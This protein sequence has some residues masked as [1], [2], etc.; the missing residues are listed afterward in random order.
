MVGT[1]LVAILLAIGMLGFARKVLAQAQTA[2]QKLNNAMSA[3][4]PSVAK[5][6]TVL[7]SVDVAKAKVLRQAAGLLRRAFQ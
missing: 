7:D 4:P 6:A 2:E 3:G 5:D 1:S